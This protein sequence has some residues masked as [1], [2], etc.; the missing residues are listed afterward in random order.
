MKHPT[1]KAER[2]HAR[3]VNIEHTK[4]LLKKNIR[5]FQELL[6]ELEKKETL[7]DFD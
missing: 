5:S 2:Q 7:H 6:D 3:K 4:T 1:N